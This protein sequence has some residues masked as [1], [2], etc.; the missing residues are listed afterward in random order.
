MTREEWLAAAVAAMRPWF[1]AEGTPL[2]EA[3]R[4][5]CGWPSRKGLSASRRRIGECWDP[6]ASAAGASEI[7]ISPCLAE[8][9]RVLDVLVHELVHAAVGVSHGHRGPFR[10]LAKA[11]GLEGRMTA[12]HAGP[13]LAARLNALAEKLGPYPHGALDRSAFGRK[14]NTRMHKAI[15]P[16]CGFTMRVAAKWAG[17]GLPVCACGEQIALA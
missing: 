11:L 14:Q 15:C 4:A 3:V 16:A 2:P 6:K 7:F 1:A 10:R 9:A 8:P 17:Y 12:T 13:Q 5:S